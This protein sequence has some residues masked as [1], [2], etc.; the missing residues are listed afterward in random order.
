LRQLNELMEMLSEKDR[1]LDDR[2][3]DGLADATAAGSVVIAA[4]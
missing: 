3:L 4:R 2:F 1:G